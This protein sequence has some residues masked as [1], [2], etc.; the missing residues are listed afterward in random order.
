MK[1]TKY[2][3]LITETISIEFLCIYFVNSFFSTE[4]NK[5]TFYIAMQNLVTQYNM[6]NVSYVTNMLQIVVTT[7]KRNYSSYSII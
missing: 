2:H 7:K 5:S 1:L 6:I 3:Y 4:G